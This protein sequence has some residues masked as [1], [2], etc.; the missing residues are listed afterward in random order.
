MITREKLAAWRERRKLLRADP[1]L[2]EVRRFRGDDWVLAS[3]SFHESLG[4]LGDETQLA[5]TYAR[6]RAAA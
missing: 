1:H 4:L 5:L 6:R 2:G 3:V